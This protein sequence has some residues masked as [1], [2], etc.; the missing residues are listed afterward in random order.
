MPQSTRITPAYAGNTRWRTDHNPPFWDH[1]RV[2]GKHPGLRHALKGVQGSPPRMRET[3]R[4]LGN[5]DWFDRI[6]PAYA[7]NTDGNIKYK[8]AEKDHPR[9]CGK[10]GANL[11]QSGGM[12]GSPPRMRETQSQSCSRPSHRGITPAYAGNTT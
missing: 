9:V 6:T 4:K 12:I 8:D 1:P 11:Y 5:D 7:G 2:C 10:H 3:L